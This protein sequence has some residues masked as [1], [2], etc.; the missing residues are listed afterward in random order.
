MSK[1]YKLGQQVIIFNEGKLQIGVLTDRKIMNKRRTF[2]VRT[3]T[4]YEIPYVPTDDKTCKIYI[5]SEKTLKFLD[6]IQ[7]NLSAESLGNIR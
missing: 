4:G 7:S 6:K 1:K 3:E 5:D 2:N